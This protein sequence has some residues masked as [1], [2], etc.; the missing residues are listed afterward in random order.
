L[1]TPSDTSWDVR[2]VAT[3]PGAAAVYARSHRFEIGA[4]LSFDRDDPR[5]SALEHVL[6]ALGSDVV[7]GLGRLAKKHRLEVFGVEATVEARLENPLTYLG[8][9]GEEGEP[10]LKSVR[11]RVYVRTPRDRQA[12]EVVWREMLATSPLVCT[13]RR[14]VELDLTVKTL[15]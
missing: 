7:V 5:V 11:V 1:Q 8:V 10:A 15:V 4:P 2:V 14:S 13:L 6:G 3:D 9:V 12:V